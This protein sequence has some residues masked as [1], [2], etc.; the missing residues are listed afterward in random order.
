VEAGNDIRKL[1]L[2]RGT[3]TAN[4]ENREQH[5]QHFHSLP[6]S[7]MGV[8]RVYDLKSNILTSRLVLYNIE[9]TRNKDGFPRLGTFFY[10]REKVLLSD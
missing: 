9:E 8:K 3:K 4:G 1:P 5:L 2:Q 6:E 10:Y 7:A